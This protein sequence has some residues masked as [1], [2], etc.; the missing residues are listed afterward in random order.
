[1]ATVEYGQVDG[2]THSNEYD[3]VVITRNT[4]TIDVF[5]SHVIL[6]KVRMAYTG[7]RI[8]MMTQ[9]L[10]VGHG[11]LPQG[12]MVQ[13]VYTKMRKGNKN[14]VMVVRNSTVYPQTLKQGQWQQLECQTHQW[15]TPEEREMSPH[16]F[17]HLS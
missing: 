5:L 13:N 17:K 8:N 11:S 15:Q 4:K 6:L 1:M 14:I 7:K 12:L 9:A 10:H 16:A 3:E 2:E